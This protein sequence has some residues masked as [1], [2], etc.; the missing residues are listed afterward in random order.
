MNIDGV[1]LYRHLEILRELDATVLSLTEA[2][3]PVHRGTMPRRPVVL[4]FD[5]WSVDSLS[6]AAP[7]LRELGLPATVYLPTYYC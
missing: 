4:T 6:A 3:I 1:R 5:D 2:L 7:L